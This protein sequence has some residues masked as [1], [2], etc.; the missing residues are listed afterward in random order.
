[1]ELLGKKLSKTAINQLIAGKPTRVMKGFTTK[2]GR[3]VSGKIRMRADGHGIE[4]VEWSGPEGSGGK[5]PA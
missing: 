4:L 2:D 1:M 3:K 5:E